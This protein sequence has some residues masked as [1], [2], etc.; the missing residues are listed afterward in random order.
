MAT[1][2]ITVK[3]TESVLEQI[4]RMR[5]RIM[6]RAY[7]ISRS[8]GSQPGGDVEHWLKAER[9]L[10]WKPSIELFETKDAYEAKI[11]L[12]G[13]DPGDFRIEVNRNALLVTGEISHEHEEENGNVIVC[14]FEQGKLFREV[15]F[16][17]QIDPDSIK[18][19]LKNFRIYRQNVAES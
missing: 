10:V 16:P 19:D 17:R 6:D 9:E 11:A 2:K 18:T 8:N 5:D 4:E 12:P 3:K 13:I 7:H 14:E 15:I 1:G